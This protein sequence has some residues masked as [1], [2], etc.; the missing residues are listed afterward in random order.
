MTNA[1]GDTTHGGTNGTGDTGASAPPPDPALIA[2][3][4][5]E[6]AQ[7]D[8]TA[9][10]NDPEDPGT[11]GI[12]ARTAQAKIHH[13]QQATVA[14]VG[15]GFECSPEQIET[16]VPQCD[17]L[18]YDFEQD[19]RDARAAIAAVY[20]PAEDEGSVMYTNKLK[21]SLTNLVGVYD[22]QINYVKWWKNTLLQAKQTYMH[23]EQIT[24]EQWQRLAKGMQA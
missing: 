1:N 14:A 21:Q 7:A 11:G 23:N 12:S 22:S 6:T 19:Q 24:E 15:A 10:A 16:L 4:R 18:I 2:Q 20:P 8:A 5:A 13:A 9:A 3:I 17:E